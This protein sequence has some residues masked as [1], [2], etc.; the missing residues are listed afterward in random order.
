[1]KTKMVLDFKFLI[2]RRQC[3]NY[4]LCA[5]YW[6]CLGL[7]AP[8]ESEEFGLSNGASHAKVRQILAPES[9][10]KVSK[11]FHGRNH[12]ARSVSSKAT[13]ALRV[14]RAINSTVFLELSFC[15]AQKC[16]FRNSYCFVQQTTVAA[17]RLKNL[18]GFRNVSCIYLV[19]IFVYFQHAHLCQLF[20]FMTFTSSPHAYHQIVTNF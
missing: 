10:L 16:N 2:N 20:T 5:C 17:A 3:E 4:N 15:A 6:H 12:V 19:F 8:S 14:T 13:R 18:S 1:L 11:L 7:C 9:P